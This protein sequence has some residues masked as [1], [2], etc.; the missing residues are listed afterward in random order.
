MGLWIVEKPSQRMCRE[1]GPQERK[2]QRISILTMKVGER[3]FCW[4]DLDVCM[5]EK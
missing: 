2:R 3:R 4:R 1:Q 5:T